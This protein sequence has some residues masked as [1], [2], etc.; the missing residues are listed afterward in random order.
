MDFHTGQMDLGDLIL[1]TEKTDVILLIN[2][3][4]NF[5][6]LHAVSMK[7]TEFINMISL[8][9]EKGSQVL[10]LQPKIYS[11]KWC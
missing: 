11:Y 9:A 1:E 6:L 5:L 7:E 3:S 4:W 10:F 2:S 8:W